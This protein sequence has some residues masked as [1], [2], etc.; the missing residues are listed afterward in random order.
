M[1][2]NS[3]G[4][5][6]M[7]MVGDYKVDHTIYR[8]ELNEFDFSGSYTSMVEMASRIQ[9]EESFN[10]SC[11]AKCLAN[12]RRKKLQEEHQNDHNENSENV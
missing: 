8:G 11:R 2:K 12:Q 1:S 5:E 3:I 7:R 9:R 10:N 6:V 4:L